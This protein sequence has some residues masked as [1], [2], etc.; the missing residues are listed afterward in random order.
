MV[1]VDRHKFFWS[2]HETW[3]SWRNIEADLPRPLDLLRPLERDS[4]RA[5]ERALWRR[6]FICHAIDRSGFTHDTRL[7]YS[8]SSLI[9]ASGVVTLDGS[10]ILKS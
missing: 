4:N 6:Q 5:Q 7:Q 3:K 1:Y 9:T 8:T 2:E 10:G